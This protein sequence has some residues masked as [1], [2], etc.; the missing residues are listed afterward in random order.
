MYDL[1]GCIGKDVYV[2][3]WSG[4]YV[5]EYAELYSDVDSY[6]DVDVF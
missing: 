4:F 3:R 5:C 6:E 1:L 2:G